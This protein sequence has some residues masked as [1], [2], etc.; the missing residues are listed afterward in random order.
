MNTKQLRYVLALAHEGSFARAAETL[1]ISQPSLS[2]YIKK[3]ELQ[4]GIELFDRAGGS[5]RLTDAG[6]E[7]V[8]AGRQILE[9]E[10]RMHS[11]FTDL[12]QHKTGS[13]VVGTSPYRSAAMMPAVAKAFQQRYSGM[14]LVVE[15]MT[16]AE[17][18]EE[19]ERGQ[20]DLCLT[21]LPVDERI[22]AYQL[23]TSEELILAVPASFPLLPA[24]E[25]GG[26]RYPAVDVRV[27]DG[28]RL[29]MLTETQ[30][31][32]RVLAD[33]CADYGIMPE[34]A[35]VVKSLEAQIAMVRAGV[36]MALV[37]SGI[38]CFCGR[39]EVRFYSFTQS[40]PRREVAAVW[41]KDRP[42]SAVASELVEIMRQTQ[43]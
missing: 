7:Y 39:D 19:A 24:P 9:L 18:L 23:I 27:L 11:R 36:G 31:M 28:Q 22:F 37:S 32:Q 38:E 41:R 15:E 8:S 5:V 13:L 30:Y 1:G 34:K 33:I 43:F 40:L 3:I 20:F 21:M 26:S 17:L 35:A 25:K 12:S 4:L 16:S 29:V 14:H 6:R 42:L 10:R 2:Q